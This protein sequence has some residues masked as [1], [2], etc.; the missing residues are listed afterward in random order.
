M[1]TQFLSNSIEIQREICKYK[2]VKYIS[3]FGS[4]GT[5]VWDHYWNKTCIIINCLQKLHNIDIKGCL[6]EI[7]FEIK[8][9]SHGRKVEY[10]INPTITSIRIPR[11]KHKPTT[12]VT[13][14]INR[15]VIAPVTSKVIRY[16]ALQQLWKG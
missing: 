9:I 1:L 2:K 13:E 5:K 15:S 10:I 12:W 8:K 7:T 16:I 4:L 3:C 6:I 11:E 14:L